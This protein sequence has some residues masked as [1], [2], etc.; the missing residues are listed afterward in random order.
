[1]EVVN[2]LIRLASRH[3]EIQLCWVPSHVEISGNVRADSEARRAAT[4][5]RNILSSY[6]P[7]KDYYPTIKTKLWCHWSTIWQNTR[8]NKLR[9]IKNTASAWKSS[10]QKQ[11]KSEIL[12]TRLRIGHCRL[13]HRYLMEGAPAPYC[14]DCLVPLTVKHVLAECPTHNHVR[15]FCYPSSSTMDVN[16]IMNLML[17]EP[18]DEPF[19]IGA[20]SGGS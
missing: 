14:E 1:M 2:W 19:D 11:R 4:S 18:K 20:L 6:L 5:T 9:E 3:K 16:D 17:A 15:R 12:L 10:A 13:S 7:Y 8:N